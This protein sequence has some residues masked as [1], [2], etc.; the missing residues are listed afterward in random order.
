MIN[1]KKGKR[2]K[3]EW[4]LWIGRSGSRK[5]VTARPVSASFTVAVSTSTA[6][7]TY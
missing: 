7:R 2:A 3:G 5:R 1:V 4:L 6:P